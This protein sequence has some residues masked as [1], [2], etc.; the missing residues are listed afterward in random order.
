[1]ST[2]EIMVGIGLTV[3][4]A[5]G[6]QILAGRLHVPAIIVLLPVGFVAGAVTDAADPEQLLGP[7]FPAVVSLAV[8]VILYDAGLSLD[9]RRMEASNHRVVVRLLLIGVPITWAVAA[10]TSWWLLGLSG[11]AAVM[12][13][14]ILVVSGP[15]VVIPLLDFVR[16]TRPLQRVLA[17]EGVLID[18]VG[19]IIG[20]LVVHAIV[21]STGESLAGGA[22]A[23]VGSVGTGLAGGLLGAG[24]LW[25]VLVRLRPGEV[26]DAGAQ[27]AVVLL[28][29]AGC[30]ALR[31][32]SGLVAAIVMGLV[33]ANRREF[34]LPVR[35]PFL[36]TLVQLIL[37]VL[38]VSIS[39]TVTP[40]SLQGLVLPTLGL[41]AALVLVAR[42]L[43][44][45][46]ATARSP[47]T[48]RER[49]FVGWMAPRGIVAAATAS[50]FGAS[51]VSAGVAG[52]EKILPV[53]FVVI[54]ATVCLYG[55]TAVPVAQRLGVVRSTESRPLLVGDDPW[56]A[57]L[58]E[59]LRDGGLNVMVWAGQEE[60]RRRIAE[61][62]LELA[63]GELLA[64]AAGQGAELEET[65]M[66][67]LLSDEDDF[68]AL[69]S[70]LLEGALDGQVFRLPPRD[71]AG[72]AVAPFLG[73]RRLFREDLTGASLDRR[74]R[75]G[76]RVITRPASPELEAGLDLLFVI[77]PGG[78]LVPVVE[79]RT[80]P[81]DEGGVCVLLATPASQSTV[82][83][84]RRS[85]R[86][87]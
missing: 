9:L 54:V 50:T 56:V 46:L 61:R 29:S 63:R 40:S 84:G 10:F 14:A 86:S 68:N 44:T 43:L 3:A 36:E 24:L 75:A 71:P 53:T 22:G 64:A 85:S 87:N 35:R 80:P 48:R 55:L 8:A 42:P 69:A 27:L 67:L 30:D 16:P 15:T 5:V 32:D 37:G 17:W 33:V 6:S 45:A 58:A 76:G 77:R 57:D 72:G 2:E 70:A 13:G 41:V 21:G 20:A 78:V 38:F 60:Q 79:G 39:A 59:A 28:V 23:F 12:L 73:G 51:L 81:L 49:I 74:H 66:V 65:T 19:A 52:A 4:L 82:A 26:L 47:L 7:A 34:D 31:D 18:P 11:Q 25:L 83:P 62:G 1:V